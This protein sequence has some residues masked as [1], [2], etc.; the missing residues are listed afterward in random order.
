MPFIGG[1]DYH[2]SHWTL[3]SLAFP[4]TPCS[5]QGGA[6]RG[7]SLPLLTLYMHA[8]VPWSVSRCSYRAVV[9]KTVTRASLHFESRAMKS[10]GKPLRISSV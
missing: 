1:C 2:V 7:C 4:F 10:V 8:G 6:R 9:Q 3:F 5:G